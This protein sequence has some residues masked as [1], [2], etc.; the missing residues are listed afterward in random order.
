MKKLLSILSVCLVFVSYSQNKVLSN[1]LEWN[2]D[3]GIISYNNEPFTGV[4]IT[5]YP[6]SGLYSEESFK[7]GVKNGL[8]RGYYENGHLAVEMNFKQGVYHG[9]ARRW[10]ENGQ[11]E[12]LGTFK[13]G[14]W[15]GLFQAWYDNGHLS[16]QCTFKDGKIDGIR[17]S[18]NADVIIEENYKDG[19][20][21]GLSRSWWRNEE[22]GAQLRN[23][24]TYKDGKL[25]GLYQRMGY[26]GALIEQSDW[27]DGVRIE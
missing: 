11:L 4:M 18:W 13:D 15:D 9:L 16:N 3:N 26:N 22:T 6:T 20:K 27:K 19:K 5:L 7:D 14:E 8:H 24:C 12:E 17:L 1:S 2:K 21:D 23:K 10:F 25:D